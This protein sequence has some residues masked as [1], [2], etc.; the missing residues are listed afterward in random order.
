MSAITSITELRASILFLEIK[1]ANEG[2]LLKEQFKVTYES[3]KPVNLLKHSLSNLAT[4][5][6]FK[7]DLLNAA[8]SLASGYLSKKVIIGA[9]S[10]PI[11]QLLGSLLQMG[12]TSLVS[13]N[14]EG[15]KSIAL[16]LLNNFLTKKD[17]DTN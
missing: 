1:Q 14:S 5:P 15:I 3:L 7:G 16:N 13:K 11:K 17:R 8:V 6:D 12:V 9:T 4:V 10:N 2:R